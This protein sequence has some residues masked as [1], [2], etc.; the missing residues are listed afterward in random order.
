MAK[1][2]IIKRVLIKSLGIGIC[3]IPVFSAILSYFPL[4]IKKADSCA[5]SGFA[6]CLILM[7]LVPFYRQ[8]L[9]VL[10][11]PAAYTLW[12]I[13]FIIFFF[14]SRIAKEM[15]V[16][17]FVGFISNLLGAL[18]FKLAD[19]HEKDEEENE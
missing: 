14:L 19:K 2:S 3:V 15:T 4:W 11:S 16:I 9:G 18:I 6:L 10:K 7:A 13:T 8:L 1:N 5:L 17:A 12:F